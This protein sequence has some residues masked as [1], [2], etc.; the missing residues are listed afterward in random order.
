MQPLIKNLIYLG[1][2]AIIGICADLIIR[3]LKRRNKIKIT[4]FG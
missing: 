4:Q 2:G 1:A 3:T